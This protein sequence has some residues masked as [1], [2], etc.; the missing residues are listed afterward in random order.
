MAKHD[1]RG[2]KTFPHFYRFTIGSAN[3]AEVIQLPGPA[4]QD[5]HKIYDG[6]KVTVHPITTDVRISHQG[7]EGS[8]LVEH[9]FTVDGDAAPELRRSSKMPLRDLYIDSTGTPVVEIVLELV[10]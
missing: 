1:L 3:E 5:T 4:G 2:V 7:S 9:F 8:Q 10:D 6:L